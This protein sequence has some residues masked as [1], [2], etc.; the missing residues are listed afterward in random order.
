MTVSSDL[1]SGAGNIQGSSGNSQI[2]KD[3]MKRPTKRIDLGAST[4]SNDTKLQLTTVKVL[5]DLP[6]HNVHQW[7]ITEEI[8][9]S[10]S[11]SGTQSPREEVYD[12]AELLDWVSLMG[13]GG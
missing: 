3:F 2:R 1:D 11:V 9:A 6:S 4:A 7:S 12:T 10:R 5:P 13:G 8:R